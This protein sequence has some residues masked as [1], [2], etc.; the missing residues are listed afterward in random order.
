[1]DDSSEVLIVLGTTS[2]PLHSY[3]HMLFEEGKP[4]QAHCHDN[5][6]PQS[7]AP[8]LLTKPARR[9]SSIGPLLAAPGPARPDD[10]CCGAAVPK[11]SS[12]SALA[13][14][15]A[16]FGGRA[17]AEAG[18]VLNAANGSSSMTAAAGG[19]AARCAGAAGM[20]KTGS[21]GNPP[22]NSPPWP[23]NGSSVTG[24]AP[25]YLAYVG[26]LNKPAVTLS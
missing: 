23:L 1:M 8:V 19:G 20:L 12:R 3:K 21:S 25:A 2:L 13:G 18:A 26:A 24:G 9:S 17:G 16:R 22:L 4:R 14:F 15:L 5:A 11:P 7:M 6:L 10:G